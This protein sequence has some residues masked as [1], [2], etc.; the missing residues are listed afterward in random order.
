MVN[1]NNSSDIQSQQLRVQQDEVS[2]DKLFS[3]V[4]RRRG[5]IFLIVTIISLTALF[6][7]YSRTPEYR[8]YSV[9]MINEAKSSGDVL[10]SV[11]VGTAGMDSRAAKKDV[12]L[13]KSM[14]IA[15]LAVRTLYKSSKKDS[16]EFF[17]NRLYHSPVSRF[18]KSFV[19]WE[20]HK[21]VTPPENESVFFRRYAM[22]LNGRIKVDATRESG[23]L[24]VSVASP[25]P[26]E[27]AFLSNTLCQVYKEADIDRNSEKYAQARR[28][29]D[30]ML[31]EQ[32]QKV[33]EADDAQ[34]KYMEGHEIYEFSGNT[35]KLLDML[36][37]TDAKYNGVITEYNITKNG[38]DFLESKLSQQDKALSARIVQNVNSQLGNIMDEIRTAESAYVRLV[39]E[40]GADA[41]E[42][43]EKK[44][45]LDTVK[46]RY[47]QLSRS[48]IA[49][50]I[51]YE[52]R[53][54]KFSID[55]IS[56]KLQVER[57]LN[58]LRFSSM[59]YSRLKQ[60]YE[61]Q[62]ATLPKKQQDYAKLVRDRDVVNKTYVFL[63]EKL[64]EARILLGSE[65][66]S[67]VLVGSAFRPF[68]PEW[69]DFKKVMSVGLALGLILSAVYVYAAETLDDTVKSEEFFKEIGLPLLSVIPVV[70][71][72]GKNAFSG[73]E[74][75]KIRRNLL[76]LFN[77]LRESAGAV[78]GK[79][80]TK[81]TVEPPV[82][83]VKLPMPKITDSMSSPFAESFRVLRTSLD[84]SRIDGELK[85]I[86]V[87]GTAM[88]EGK[89]TVCSNLAMAYALVGKKTLIIDCDLRRASQHT[90]FGCKKH[91][92]LT[93]YL[94]SS[95]HS[96]DSSYFKPTHMENLFLLTAG[97][98]VPNPN[99]LLG[100][101]KMLK[102][103]KEL[104]T[105]C[106]MIILDSPPLFLSDAAQLARAVDGTLMVARIKYSSRKP[107]EEYAVDPYLRPMSLGV[108][109]IA[110]RDSN[111]YG[112]G[113]Y[114]YGKYGYGKY[115]YGKYGYGKYGYGKYGYGKYEEDEESTPA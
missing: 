84:Y 65:V 42:V 15:E 72:D 92:G 97:K 100:S 99:E 8:A 5:G 38:L 1:Q 106:D 33:K 60:Y 96:I 36:I 56:E 16:L 25:F 2:F 30:S 59:E 105:Q 64:D 68:T 76:K 109:A 101:S 49:G 19:F 74:L 78:T 11:L 104:E 6:F 45:L 80:G 98:K 39:S 73:D 43:K 94:Y 90:K 71:Q 50:Q 81:T 29:I 3:I 103:L 35:Q 82:L 28:F 88:A 57:K 20:N 46:A 62:L 37:E 10:S 70:T 61:S 69:P 114:G 34:S 51:G 47:D 41:L 110:P 14:P 91:H 87:S 24:R 7:Y 66:G 55:M 31:S 26:D 48:K 79:D 17:G 112:Y 27:A 89:S 63:K 44:R 102:L 77:R 22:K 111:R 52:G 9:V 13:L 54:Q 75:S 12:E 83:P 32:E 53:A 115:G 23:I 40:K 108:V 107:L 58:D 67:V 113:K 95:A 18:F 4:L 85:S 21:K 86:L 93:D